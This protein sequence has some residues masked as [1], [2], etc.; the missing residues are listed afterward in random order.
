MLTLLTRGLFLSKCD[1]H[2][3]ARNYRCGL[4]VRNDCRLPYIFL[5]LIPLLTTLA[6]VF[7]KKETRVGVMLSSRSLWVTRGHWSILS[8]SPSE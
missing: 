2:S 6:C 7:H 3:W 1:V 5:D 4:T 8:Q